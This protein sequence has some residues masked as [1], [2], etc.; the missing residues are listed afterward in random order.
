MGKEPVGEILDI[1]GCSFDI[2]GRP[3]DLVDW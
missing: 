1:F 3:N 2:L